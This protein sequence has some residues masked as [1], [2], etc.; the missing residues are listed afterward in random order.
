MRRDEE[1]E[2]PNSSPFKPRR[3]DEKIQKNKC[4]VDNHAKS[5]QSECELSN[6]RRPLLPQAEREEGVPG[7]EEDIKH[8]VQNV[9]GG[10]VAHVPVQN[11]C[12]GSK[13]T[14]RPKRQKAVSQIEHAA[15]DISDPA[16]DRVEVVKETGSY[17]NGGGERKEMS[18]L[19]EEKLQFRWIDA[20]SRR[21]RRAQ[22]AD[23]KGGRE[24]TRGHSHSPD[25]AQTFGD[26]GGCGGCCVTPIVTTVFHYC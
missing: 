2:T 22:V 14:Q 17:Q 12:V 21:F 9:V 23:R 7:A 13:F 10:I 19:D 5:V 24:A 25:S 8:Q 11:Q 16:L 20:V 1:V 15:T 4:P 3:N 6:E 18:D 26:A